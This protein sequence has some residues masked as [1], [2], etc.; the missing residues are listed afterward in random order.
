M[1]KVVFDLGS[2]QNKLIDV[3]VYI[4]I[5]AET[6]DLNPRVMCTSKSNKKTGEP[7]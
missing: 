7:S 1:H 6:S 5:N 4:R 2:G 3:E